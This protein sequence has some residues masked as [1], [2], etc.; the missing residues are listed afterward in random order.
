MLPTRAGGVSEPAMIRITMVS[1]VLAVAASC[2]WCTRGRPP[3]PEPLK[4]DAASGAIPESGG[5]RPQLDTQPVI[6]APAPAVARQ[7]LSPEQI[8]REQAEKELL[9]QLEQISAELA[10]LKQVALDARNNTTAELFEA[11]DKV[12]EIAGRDVQFDANVTR[13]LAGTRCAIVLACAH[14][15][16]DEAKAS[17]S[18]GFHEPRQS[19]FDYA[20]CEDLLVRLLDEC[21]KGSRKDA[22]L[23]KVLT[24]VYKSM[25]EEAD[26]LALLAYTPGEI[27]RTPWTELMSGDQLDRWQHPGFTSWQI[28][29]GELTCNTDASSRNT[30]IM[31]IGDREL[32]RDYVFEC[33]ITLVKG[34]AT[35]HHRLGNVVNNRV[36]NTKF[37]S[38]GAQGFGL[39]TPIAV[40]FSVIG[41]RAELS[42]SNTTRPSVIEDM[43]WNINRKGAIGI[44]VPAGSEIKVS[45]MRVQVLR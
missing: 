2:L 28:T 42:F 8:E 12:D 37:V 31:S 32:W 44:S 16:H 35:F 26:A 9:K 39:G 6:E 30:A 40:R 45:K 20:R 34:E 14:R 22:E 15:L 4:R 23:Q 19:L 41:S 25:I 10:A 1:L 7:P 13:E 36:Y 43:S 5:E 11:K 21:S 33:E 38:E 24:D 3:A 27:E 18:S 17:A 29:A